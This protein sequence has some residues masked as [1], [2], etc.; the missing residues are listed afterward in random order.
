MAAT[1]V[2]P[3]VVGVAV[4]VAAI[5]GG[6]YLL[7]IAPA[8]APP[9]EVVAFAPPGYDPAA[10][11]SRPLPPDPAVVDLDM[12]PQLQPGMS[13]AEVEDVIGLPPSGHVE[14]IAG[15]INGRV[16]YRTAYP[17]DLTRGGGRRGGRAAPPPAPAGPQ[18]CIA[19]E[20]DATL[21]GHPLVNVYYPDPLF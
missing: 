13:R 1:R 12:L 6:W 17:M 14:P 7:R 18:C 16:T 20:F 4:G 9:V 21:P 8:N 15:G 10:A 19:F 3:V 2:V 11:R 5:A